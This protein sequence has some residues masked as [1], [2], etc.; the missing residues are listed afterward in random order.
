M[1]R[2]SAGT[3][4]ITN[5]DPVMTGKIALAHLNELADY[6]T[7]FKKMEDAQILNDAPEAFLPCYYHKIMAQDQIMDIIDEQG[8]VTGI[9]T[10]K[11]RTSR[12]CCAKQLSQKLLIRPGDG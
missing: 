1:E 10:K 9:V 6:Y 2:A 11:K 3:R 8:K 4:N 5:D 7:R 12:D